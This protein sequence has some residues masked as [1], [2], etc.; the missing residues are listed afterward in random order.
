MPMSHRGKGTDNPGD[1]L[2]AYDGADALDP[3]TTAWPLQATRGDTTRR[4]RARHERLLRGSAEPRE[5]GVGSYPGHWRRLGAFPGPTGLWRE[6]TVVHLH[7]ALQVLGTLELDAALGAA[8]A[9]AGPVGG[10]GRGQATHLSV[11]AAGHAA[12]TEA[13][14]EPVDV[15]LHQVLLAAELLEAQGTL[16]ELL[17]PLAVGGGRSRAARQLLHVEGAVD[18]ELERGGDRLHA[19]DAAEARE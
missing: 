17:Q 19:H 5:A 18:L 15:E 10:L 8:E 16:V 4:Y 1:R 7:V 9:G 6:V 12:G 3:R 13:V 14:G 11:G 2:G